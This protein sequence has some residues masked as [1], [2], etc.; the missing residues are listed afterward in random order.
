MSHY[1]VQQKYV[2]NTI[3]NYSQFSQQL[4]SN[5]NKKLVMQLES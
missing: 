5:V 3:V 2:T 1:K 4:N